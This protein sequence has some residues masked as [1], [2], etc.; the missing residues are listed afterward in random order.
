MSNNNPWR[1]GSNRS[2]PRRDVSP[3]RLHQKSGTAN[4]FGGYVKV[5][6]QNGTFRMRPFSR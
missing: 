2:Q 3:A 4:A 5:S 1:A 6:Y